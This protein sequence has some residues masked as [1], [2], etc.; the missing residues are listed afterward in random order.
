MPEPA[1]TCVVPTHDRP[2]LLPRALRSVLA[3]TRPP[4]S[5]IVVDDTGSAGP[6]V[7]EFDGRVRY[8]RSWSSTAGASRNLGAARAG[9]PL[10]AFLD[11]DDTWH[12]TFL[13][14]CVAE[15]AESTVDFAAAWTWRCRA[16]HRRPGGSLPP[17]AVPADWLHRNPGLTG[18]N[19][20]VRAE[21]FGRL[22]GF[23]AALPVNS[24]LDLFVRALDLGLRYA[25]V[26]ERLV[27]QYRNLSSRGPRRASGL[28]GYRHKYR[29]RLTVGQRRF[30]RREQYLALRFPDQPH[31]R[32][33]AYALL[34]W[35]NATPRQCVDVVWHRLNGTAL[36]SD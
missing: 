35:L 2:E 11:D 26:P 16:G 15:L 17:A 9:T 21:A 20:V 27:V 32:R 10:L 28:A 14:R 30:L 5:V 18:S 12:P 29:D 24:D 3:Q 1:V 34:G 4:D 7:A 23:D 8:V 6:V 31:R 33:L 22:G 13:D 25:V 19:F 36:H